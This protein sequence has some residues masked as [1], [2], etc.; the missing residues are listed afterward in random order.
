MTNEQ[1]AALRALAMAATGGKWEEETPCS[2]SPD[3]MVGDQVIASTISSDM[4][5]QM[6]AAN[7]AYIVASQPST[8]LALLDALDAASTAA[9]RGKALDRAIKA[10]ERGNALD[11]AIK[12]AEAERIEWRISGLTTGAAAIRLAIHRMEATR[13]ERD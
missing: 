7:A 3:V 13:H 4:S 5:R 10:A 2:Y 6:D 1:R 12:A 11:R 8:I 9:E